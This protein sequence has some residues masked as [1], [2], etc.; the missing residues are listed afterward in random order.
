MTDMTL[1]EE[2]LLVALDDAKGD[3][4]ANWGSGI[5]AGLAGAILLELALAGCVHPEDGKL[6]AAECDVPGDPL[7]ARA[8]EFV[9]AE[10]KPRDAKHWVGR[11]KKELNPMRGKVAER[12]VERGVLGEE[13][14]KLLGLFSATAYPE[15]DPGPERRLREDL[16][17]VLVT[18]RDPTAHEAML[19][20][21]L[22]ANDLVKRVVPK[23]D[24]KA[25]RKRATEIAKGENVGAAVSRVVNDFD[26]A[27]M[28]AVISATAVTTSFGGDGGGGSS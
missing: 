8:Y 18:G 27:T 23:D 10:E 4:T 28:T 25:A 12:L 24:R 1:A 2:L 6:A 26:V 16:A 13:K 5:E 17:G 19:V 22:H 3:D 15:R 21:L 11:L 9:R 20:S 14:R 7:A